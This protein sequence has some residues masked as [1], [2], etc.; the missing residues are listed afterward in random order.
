MGYTF[1]FDLAS[2]PRRFTNELTKFCLENDITANI[3]KQAQYFVMK[4]KINKLAGISVSDANVV[5]EDLIT[6]QLHNKTIDIQTDYKRALLL[7]HCAR[8][9]MDDQC[10]AIFDKE[11]SSY[12]CTSCSKNCLINWATK[13]GIKMGYDVY[14][15]PGG[16]C[17]SK[18]LKKER[19]NVIIGVACGNEVKLALEYLRKVGIKT[20]G[21]PLDK[22]G[23]A[24][25]RFSRNDLKV[26]L[27]CNATE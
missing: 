8:K 19:Y 23:C 6:I 14:V 20:K 18:I 12:H 15:L 2:L 17:L 27:E 10:K 9:H 21:L 3:R 16:S 26:L 24:K 25:T 22:N 4:F 13:L 7:P 1:N 11:L 5:I